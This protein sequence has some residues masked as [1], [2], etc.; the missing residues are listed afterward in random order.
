MMMCKYCLGC[1]KLELP[2]FKGA[3]KCENAVIDTKELESK[4]KYDQIKL[5]GDRYDF[6]KTTTA[7]RN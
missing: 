1:N 7:R 5:K 3:Y 4:K 2:G 6:R